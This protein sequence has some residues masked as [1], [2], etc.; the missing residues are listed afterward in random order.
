[1][2]KQAELA[3][4]DRLPVTGAQQQAKRS[5]FCDQQAQHVLIHNNSWAAAIA[6]AVPAAAG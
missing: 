5:V 1:M 6:A 2:T 4:T 3:S